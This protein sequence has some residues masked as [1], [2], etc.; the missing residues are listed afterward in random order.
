MGLYPILC[1]F[2]CYW[3]F[4]YYFSKIYIYSKLCVLIQMCLAAVLDVRGV[5]QREI[6]P[7]GFFM[8]RIRILTSWRKWQHLGYHIGTSHQQRQG[9]SFRHCITGLSRERN[10]WAADPSFC[11]AQNSICVFP[12]VSPWLLPCDIIQSGLWIQLV[13][14]T[15]PSAFLAVSKIHRSMRD[16]PKNRIFMY[17]LLLINA[18]IWK[19]GILFL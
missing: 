6:L 7:W 18:C 9:R 8:L 15:S 19:S 12:S 13:K 2:I 14:V 3:F 5:W 17:Y 16:V 1:N 10:C 4:Y 11:P